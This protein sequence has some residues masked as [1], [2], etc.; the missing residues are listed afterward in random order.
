MCGQSRLASGV[1][2]AH[3]QLNHIG[4]VMDCAGCWQDINHDHNLL[5]SHILFSRNKNA[6]FMFQNMHSFEI[7]QTILIGHNMMMMYD[8]QMLS[9]S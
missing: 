9:Y 8:T 4:F 6:T 7:Y 1:T 5:T 2:L 3:P